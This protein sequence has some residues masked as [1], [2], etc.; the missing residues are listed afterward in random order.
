MPHNSMPLRVSVQK[1]PPASKKSLRSDALPG[2]ARITVPA[3]AMT[4][5]KTCTLVI[6]TT[7]KDAKK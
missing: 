4:A 5:R 2:L 1:R 6:T 3:A 7:P